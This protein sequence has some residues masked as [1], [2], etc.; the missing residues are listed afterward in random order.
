MKFGL[1]AAGVTAP[2]WCSTAGVKPTFGL[3]R[4]GREVIRHV[5]GT[6]RSV[7]SDR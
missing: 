5:A 1:L 2:A 7:A 6:A 3:R 4:F